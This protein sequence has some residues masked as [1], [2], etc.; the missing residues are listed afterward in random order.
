[1]PSPLHMLAA[2]GDADVA[3][4]ARLA[5]RDPNLVVLRGSRS[6]PGEGLRARLNLSVRAGEGVVVR[7]RALDERYVVAQQS[8]DHLLIHLGTLPRR[9]LREPHRRSGEEQRDAQKALHRPSS[10]LDTHCRPLPD[11]RGLERLLQPAAMPPDV[12][13]EE[14]RGDRKVALSGA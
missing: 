5:L 4:D 6:N 12:D 8:S 9:P 3:I 10:A 11:R 2:G 1:A 13:A 14:A 7:E